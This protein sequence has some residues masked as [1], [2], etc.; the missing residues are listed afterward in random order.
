MSCCP[1][2]WLNSWKSFGQRATPPQY[3]QEQLL[4]VSAATSLKQAK[5]LLDIWGF[6]RQ[7]IFLLYKFYLNPLMLLLKN[8]PILNEVPTNEMHLNVSK[9]QDGRHSHQ[10][11]PESLSLQRLQEPPLLP[12]G[13]SG[14][15]RM[16]IS[17]LCRKPFFSGAKA[18]PQPQAT[19]IR[20]TTAGY[21]SIPGPS[22]DGDSH[23]RLSMPAAQD[24]FDHGGSTPPY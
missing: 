6:P 24:A 23:R 18:A 16:A 10:C 5:H 4:T 7:Y 15:P 8:Q 19:C 9:V 22:A 1:S 20:A 2:I 14:P 3:C 21:L 13:V 12:P 11:L 17:C